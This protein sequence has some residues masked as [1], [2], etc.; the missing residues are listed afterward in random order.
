M[1]DRH[2]AHRARPTAWSIAF[3]LATATGAL[4]DGPRGADWI[5]NDAVAYVEVARPADLLERLTS[6]P[7]PGL[8]GSIPDYR[9]YLASDAYRQQ[10]KAAEAVASRLGTTW[11]R[12]LLDLLGGGMVL[13]V[14]PGTPPRKILV[15]TPRDP[16][17]LARALETLLAMAR[18]DAA[19]KGRPDPIASSEH[20]GIRGYALLGPKATLA[21]VDGALVV[22][23]SAETLHL[24]IDR[25]ID[26]PEASKT[27]AGDPLWRARRAAHLSG[28]AAAWSLVRI[29]R[30]REMDR[31]ALKVPDQVNP[32]ATVLF[33]DWIETLRKSPWA[34]ASLTWTSRRLG[35]DLT[36]PTPP[37]GYSDALRRFLPTKGT[38]APA[39]IAP[40]GMVASITLWRDLS[41]LWEVRTDLFAP[42]VLQGF[43][44]FDTLAGTFFG[45]RDFGTGVLSSLGA[46]WRLIVARQDYSAMDPIPGDKL[47]AFALVADLKPGDDE[48]A[49]RLTSAF[50]SFVG[51]VNLGA[52]QSKAPPLM[53]GSETVDGVT[54]A[55][56]RFLKPR[57]GSGAGEPVNSRHNFSPSAAQV[58][59]HFLLSSSLG[60]ARDLIPALKAPS[61]PTDATLLV[62]ADGGELSGLLLENRPRLVMQ[63]MLEKGNDKPKAEAEVGFLG[64]VLKALGRGSLSARDSAE[65]VRLR[66]DFALDHP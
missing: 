55:T 56:S 32:L 50:Q 13:A 40:R 48:F 17:F 6:E 12:G 45:G 14:E 7:V 41:S 20:R 43:A 5:G 59:D 57:K 66:L 31:N 16:A 23:D 29:D 2:P 4:A 10:K 64:R 46:D 63:N 15:A 44:Q 52:A 33:A 25:S 18:D 38:G 1:S 37:G 61:G 42:P 65:G 11:D 24:V 54:I 62:E 53:L 39:P 51:L 19:A 27:L 47:P 36:L 34:S 28:E 9:K 35:A 26:R 60:L 49:V 21:V 30:L 22:G 8:L 3:A 58:G